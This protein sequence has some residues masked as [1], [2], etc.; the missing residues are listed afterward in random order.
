MRIVRK[1]LVLL[2]I[3]SLLCGYFAVIRG[4]SPYSNLKL[5]SDGDNISSVLE[6]SPALSSDQNY[7]N[8]GEMFSN[9]L[10]DFSGKGYF[11]ETYD[12][13]LAGTYYAV[14]ILNATD[15]LDSIN[16]TKIVNFIM[17]YYNESSG[18]FVDEYAQRYL[19]IDFSSEFYSYFPFTTLLEVNC[20]TILTLDMLGNLSL[21][22]KQGAIDFIWSCYNPITGGFIGRPYDV[23]LSNEFK[24]STMDNTYFALITLDF[25][26]EGNWVGYALEE[27]ST[28]GFINSLQSTGSSFGAFHNDLELMNFGSLGWDINILS[29]YYCIKSLELFGVL[30][31][32]RIDDFLTYLD[33]IYREEVD[34]FQ[35]FKTA[36]GEPPDE[37]LNIPSTAI[38]LELSDIVSFPSISRSDVLAFILSGRNSI[39]SWDQINGYGYHELIDSYQV[40]R[41]LVGARE[42]SQLTSNDISDI[43]NAMNMYASGDGYSTLSEDYSSLSQLYT[44]VNSFYLYDRINDLDIGYIYSF[45]D[46]LISKDTY[47]GHEFGTYVT[48]TEPLTTSNSIIR[49]G[50]RIFPI[51]YSYPNKHR[52]LNT[53]YMALD[54]LEKIY[55]LDD[56]DISYNLSD[57][58]LEIIDSQYLN[59][60]QDNYGGFMSGSYLNPLSVVEEARN[61]D[62]QFE[63]SYWA[64]KSLE[65]IS[66]YK[67]LG[68]YDS[69]GIDTQSLYSYIFE[70][71]IET[72]SVLYYESEYTDNIE[73]NL[74]NTYYMVYV[75]EE[76]GLYNLDGQ[77]IK[78]YI[79]Q[80]IDYGNIKNIYYSWKINEYLNLSIIFDVVQTHD[81]IQS[82]YSKEY[83]EF[84]LTTNRSKLDQEIFL[85]V[86]D[87]ARNDGVRVNP[88]YQSTVM[89]GS[90][91][92]F[93]VSLWNIIL[94]DFGPNSVVKLE[95]NQLG[96]ISLTKQSDNTFLKDIFISVDPNNFP[97]IDGKICVY[98]GVK[99]ITDFSISFQTSYQLIINNSVVKN[100]NML[101]F[102]VEISFITGQGPQ[103]CFES[104]V[105]VDIYKDGQFIEKIYFTDQ[106]GF[107]STIYYLSYTLPSHGVF[108]FDVYVE[109]NY[110]QGGQ[111]LLFSESYSYEVDSVS[112]VPSDDENDDDVGEDEGLSSSQFLISIP[113]AVSLVAVPSCVIGLSHKYKVKSKEKFKR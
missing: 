106:D 90:Y 24:V 84:Y 35:N 112:G 82:I 54:A 108:S 43:T 86:S 26:M 10:D 102:E 6:R 32:V 65:L 58:I 111:S 91:N 22:D 61:N 51:E 75:L 105:M 38:G 50:F 52:S 68:D 83:N 37:M 30:D 85:W 5:S 56:F 29:S 23:G 17:S 47:I 40:I 45:I 101:D 89:L 41:S 36:V 1:Y 44:V 73:D 70:S 21:I 55:K 94:E 87:M 71:I 107:E 53:L 62:V 99:Q 27:A 18:F 31:S 49:G 14:Y 16:S 93:N 20:Y 104:D 78:N 48:Q 60:L 9:K 97:T 110:Q 98:E 46:S 76:I 39:G 2:T 57:T 28:I 67:G 95:S 69:M 64:I 12:P 66:D 8:I 103:P 4:D 79:E 15:E 80:N 42:I 77:K 88:T 59:D 100:S 3:L 25:L 72:P 92:T 81:L 19:D 7:E 109:D 96:A 11:P 63:H 34:W 13:S 74:E 113:I 33:D